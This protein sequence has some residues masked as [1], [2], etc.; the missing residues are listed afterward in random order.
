M[1]RMAVTLVVALTLL[2]C[3]KD[4]DKSNDSDQ[5]VTEEA[6]G[7]EN[8]DEKSGAVE[9]NNGE[10]KPQDF[11]QTLATVSQNLGAFLQSDSFR[12]FFESPVN[13]DPRPVHHEAI[14]NADGNFWNIFHHGQYDH[15]E[16][17]L[18]LYSQEL[19]QKIPDNMHV[20]SRTGFLHAWK[21]FERFRGDNLAIDIPGLEACSAEFKRANELSDMD[22]PV[23][24]GFWASCEVA[25]A[26]LTQDAP[27]LAASEEIVG[28]ALASWPEF[29]LFTIGYVLTSV[30][31]S[32][33]P[34]YD[35]GLEMFF[36]NIESCFGMEVDRGSPM[37]PP[38]N[39]EAAVT[40]GRKRTCWNSEKAPHNIEGFSMSFGDAL[41]KKGNF[42]GAMNMYL[43]ALGISLLHME[44]PSGP[45]PPEAA[46]L[47]EAIGTVGAIFQQGPQA[48]GENLMTPEFFG[49][50]TV[51]ASA[52]ANAYPWPYTV[53]VIEKILNLIKDMQTNSN[54]LQL[55]F[56]NPINEV[57]GTPQ[58]PAMM[59]HSKYSCQGCHGKINPDDLSG[60][61]PPQ[62]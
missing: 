48:L 56:Q 1:I 57:D 52:P 32:E 35:L 21:F 40:E 55:K 15:L 53:E 9:E 38:Y 12:K 6:Q 37:L 27:R 13:I 29:N 28:K 39:P 16:D 43:G 61:Q 4:K 51:M 49:N 22:D 31:P 33:T 25:I 18:G 19:N 17:I 60:Q 7:D 62:Q 36:I 58:S 45:M 46:P 30:L 23:Y 26:F 50:L 59:L 14:G 54:S 41:V 5:K 8:L 11:N 44:A 2:S 34:T 47:F 20:K 10:P 3:D 42:G 24:L